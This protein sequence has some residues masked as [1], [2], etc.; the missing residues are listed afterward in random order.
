MV[1]LCVN[2]YKEPFAGSG[3]V[4]SGFLSGAIYT[5]SQIAGLLSG[6]LTPSCGKHAKGATLHVPIQHHGK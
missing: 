5:R 2:D 4:G 3:N 6:S 1:H